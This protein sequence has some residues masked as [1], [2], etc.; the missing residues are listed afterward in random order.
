M[1]T[2]LS[3]PQ[4][5]TPY[6]TY[7][8]GV[9]LFNLLVI[10][11][12]T[13][14][15]ATGSGAGCGQHW[16]T[17]QGVVIPVAPTLH[18][19][20]E[21]THRAVSGLD[22]F[23]VLGLLIGAFRLYPK[24]HSVRRAAPVAALLTIVEALLGAVLVKRGYVA[25]DA[26]VGRA[27]A[28]S[29]HLCTTFFLLA[30][31]ALTSWYAAG[32][33]RVR[34]FSQGSVS[35]ALAL[36]F[37]AM[38]VLGVS[39]A[40]TA[41]GDTLFPAK[42]HEDVMRLAEQANAPFLLKLRIWH[43]YIA[44]SVGLYL[45]LIAGLVAHLRPSSDSRRWAGVLGW[46]FLAE[47]LIGLTNVWL[48]APVAMQVIHLMFADFV[49][50]ALT[51]L[52]Y[53]A[54]VDGAVRV[55]DIIF[56]AGKE[57]TETTLVARADNAPPTW[58]DYR[59]LTKPRV[60]SLLLFTTLTAA[61]VAAHGW[62]G[63]SLFLV[64]FVG[65]YCSAGAANAFNMVIDRDIDA[66]MT[67]TAKRPTVTATIPAGK[68]LGFALIMAFAS[69]VTLWLGANLLAAMLSLCG[70]VFYVVVYTLLLKRRTVQNIVIG[71]AAGCFPPLVGW[72]AVTGDLKGSLAW[73][74]FAIIFVWTPAHFWALALLIK[75]QYAAVGV[76]MLPAV[77]GDK[78]TVT[79]IILYAVITV[80][81]SL[82][83]V[84][85]GLAGALYAIPAVALG[86]MLVQQS[87]KL[88]RGTDRLSAL[89]TYKYSM[90]YLALLFLALAVDARF[91]R[92]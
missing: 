46:L 77:V 81:V 24:G 65:G 47:I 88:R 39:G 17:C 75:D 11:V 74:L 78:K 9:L 64:L 44:G 67:R 12:G 57:A 20:I 53:S 10:L 45:L 8:S 21:Y 15:R 69:F 76:P 79:Q 89:K 42:S 60:I 37:L 70:L 54:S 49:W 30:S 84:A 33:G 83:P 3:Q 66:K 6:A 18:T 43:P 26:S 31:L 1:D 41:L 55:E 85:Q 48:R 2:T 16:P 56:S 36:A 38:L 28:M 62:P 14:V 5:N 91:G 25:N 52:A 68:A 7:A 80:G 92:G 82:L 90:L 34:L 19:I 71:G 58:R 32:R 87:W 35:G 27:V 29:V 86:A 4:K 50:V 40:I 13:V 59:D 51:L 73:Y 72:A 23:L 63:L 61:F 22:G